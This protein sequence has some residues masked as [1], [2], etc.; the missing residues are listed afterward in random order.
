MIARL[1]RESA[2]GFG[3]SVDDDTALAL[4]EATGRSA[5]FSDPSRYP[6]RPMAGWPGASPMLLSRDPRSSRIGLSSSFL[7]HAA[8]LPR[9]SPPGHL[10]VPGLW[11]SNRR[12][13]SL[14]TRLRAAAPSR[15]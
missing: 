12:I 4:V 10:A 7:L 15:E 1:T 11:A 9:P 2:L 3:A 6:R 8:A 14:Q 5:G 13:K